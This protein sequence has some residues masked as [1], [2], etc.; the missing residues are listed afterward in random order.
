[1]K[2]K[3]KMSESGQQQDN[4]VRLRISSLVHDQKGGRTN[5]QTDRQ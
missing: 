5:T 1:M 3:S 2:L 4:I